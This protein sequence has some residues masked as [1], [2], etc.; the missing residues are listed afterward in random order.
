MRIVYVAAGAAGSYCGACARDVAFAR[1]VAQRGHDVEVVPLYTP[2]R[3]D[4][5]D[6]SGP[7]VFYGGLSVYLQQNIP[8]AGKMPRI[9]KRIID[10]PRVLDW[11]SGFAIET[12]PAQLGPMTVSVLRGAEGRQKRELDE[13]LV[14]LQAGPKP[15]VVHITNSL[16]SGIAPAISDT[17][18]CLVVCSLAGEDAFIDALGEPCRTEALAALAVNAGSVGLFVSPGEGYADEMAALLGTKRSKFEVVPVGIDTA[19]FDGDGQR[20]RGEGGGAPFRIGF[21]SRACP[22]KGL[23]ILVDAFRLMAEAGDESSVLAVGGQWRGR[24]KT[25]WKDMSRRL[26]AN[27]LSDRVECAGEMDLAG[28]ADF[29]RS[30]SV[31]CLPS[32]QVE[33]L[34]VSAVEA[35]AAGAAL[36]APNRG[37]FTEMAAATDGVVLVP[38]EDTDSLAKTLSSLRDDPERVKRLGDA[39]AEGIRS[40][41]SLDAASDAVLGHYESRLASGRC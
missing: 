11:I 39:A 20:P 17:L 36:V 5:P 4:G 7:R 37:V 1:G 23:D 41:Y 2:L 34:A 26:E 16:L 27:G 38:P 28:K 10:S 14:H 19:P 32:R 29:L 3:V 21:L 8:L 24:G 18:G 35:M 15:D 22:E 31:F 30:L 40:R 12:N 9:G 13:L 25:M 6:P 33:R